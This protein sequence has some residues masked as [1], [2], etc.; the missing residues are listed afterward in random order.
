[1]PTR[2]DWQVGPGGQGPEPV[3]PALV[4]SEIEA[5]PAGARRG[6][7]P[8]P[9]RVRRRSGAR[10]PIFVALYLLVL[11]T[12]ALVGFGLG[13][14]SELQGVT[15]RRIENQIAIESLAWRDADIGLI[16]STLDPAAP[17]DWR[18]REIE[19]F[20]VLSPLPFQ[21][22]IVSIELLNPRLARVVAAVE[23]PTR[24]AVETRFYR[25]A[26]GIWYRTAGP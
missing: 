10:L 15:R 24:D 8:E 7:S 5:R 4:T 13:R 11:G 23:Q 2:L 3:D 21:A 25:W 1:M 17:A 22:R 19:S 20:R 14:W 12:A 18:R 26:D 6:V 16:E 9:A